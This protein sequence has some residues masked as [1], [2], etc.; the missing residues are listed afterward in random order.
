MGSGR[1]SLDHA[2]ELEFVD[3]DGL[4]VVEVEENFV[5]RGGCPVA[6]EVGVDGSEDS[7]R[8]GVFGEGGGAGADVGH[9]D[10]LE[11]ALVG[12]CEAVVDGLGEV[13][14][15][16][17]HSR[18]L[19]AGSVAEHDVVRGEVVAVDDAGLVGSQRPLG[20][21]DSVDGGAEERAADLLQTIAHLPGQTPAASAWDDQ[22][23][24]GNAHD[25]AA[26]DAELLSARQRPT[27]QRRHSLRV[28]LVLHR[29]PLLP[30]ALCRLRRR[31]FHHL[32]RR[33]LRRS[34][35]SPDLDSAIVAIADGADRLA[36]GN[37]AGAGDGDVLE[38]PREVLVVAGG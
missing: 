9:A 36:T 4:V 6:L 11:L 38:E 30:T 34:S 12:E 35:G 1:S 19:P 26:D 20:G 17:G 8:G 2:A 10:G 15:G 7:L 24:A 28:L 22:D 18:V 25:V 29:L 27:A 3:V 14:D 5:E 13:G 21:G 31:L 32:P 16:V 33:I 23:V 37:D